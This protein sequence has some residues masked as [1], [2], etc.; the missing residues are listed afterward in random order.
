MKVINNQ[1]GMSLI[2]VMVAM[3]VSILVLS[4]TTQTLL[5]TSKQMATAAMDSE[6]NA[7]TMGQQQLVKAGVVPVA[8]QTGKG[9]QVS[10]IDTATT[11]IAGNTAISYTAVIRRNPQSIIG[12]EWVTRSL[13][14]AVT[15]LPPVAENKA[16]PPPRHTDNG[17]GK[18]NDNSQGRDDKNYFDADVAKEVMHDCNRH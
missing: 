13:G 7:W 6:I 9:W 2:S 12:P 8:T 18:S 1:R 11:T 3:A 4:F 16:T 10:R 17:N 15:A 14:T 5:L